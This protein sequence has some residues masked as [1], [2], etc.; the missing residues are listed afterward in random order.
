[1]FLRSEDGSAAAELA[2][3]GPLFCLILAGVIEL[4]G[5]VQTAQVVRNAARE[6]ARYASVSDV[7]PQ[8]KTLTYLSTSLAGRT[9]VTLPAKTAI[10]VTGTGLGNAVTVTVPVTV[11]IS[12]PVIQDVLGATVPVTGSAT[13]RITQ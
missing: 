2:I 3:L 10:T 7:D 9:D 8:A 6:G 11:K 1:M 13:M 4:G 12:V 5:V